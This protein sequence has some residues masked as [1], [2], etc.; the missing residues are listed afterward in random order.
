MAHVIQAT[1]GAGSAIPQ[2]VT[3]FEA[4]REARTDVH[5]L[6]DGTTG[7]VYRTPAL[8][9]GSFVMV[10]LSQAE[11]FAAHA[12]LAQRCAFRYTTDNPAGFSMRFAVAGGRITLDRDRDVPSVWYVTAPFREVSS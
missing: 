4:E 8:R 10:F 11:A 1:N 5:T 7:T 3:G 2:A 6:L 9:A 12:L